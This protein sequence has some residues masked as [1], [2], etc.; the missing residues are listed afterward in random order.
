L[1]SPA[2][3]RLRSCEALGAHKGLFPIR[4]VAAHHDTSV[5]EIERTY[6][7]YILA[8]ADTLTRAALL[9]LTHAPRTDNV[10]T[11]AHATA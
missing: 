6:S 2:L 8:D 11:L 7:K 3:N 4:I 9:E 1:W 10:V 5:A